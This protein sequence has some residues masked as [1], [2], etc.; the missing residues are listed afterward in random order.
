MN[1]LLLPDDAALLANSEDR[2]RQ[3]RKGF[4]RLRKRRN[5]RVNESKNKAMKCTRVMDDFRMNVT[6]KGKLI[7][8]V[9]CFECLG[10]CAPCGSGRKDR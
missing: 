4:E 5:L 3:L 8:E 6:L 10:S 2:L 9:D 1:H 7:G